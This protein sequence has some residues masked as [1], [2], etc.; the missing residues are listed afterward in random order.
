MLNPYEH[1]D[2][3]PEPT[4]E[5]KTELRKMEFAMMNIKGRILQKYDLHFKKV[6]SNRANMQLAKYKIKDSNKVIYV[7]SG[8]NFVGFRVHD[9]W[10]GFCDKPVQSS[11]AVHYKIEDI[12]KVFDLIEKRNYTVEEYRKYIIGDRKITAKWLDGRKVFPNLRGFNRFE[13]M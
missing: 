5:F 1:W 10:K 3:E 8:K 2:E 7:M 4:T 6:H 13:R 12:E 11:M 9:W